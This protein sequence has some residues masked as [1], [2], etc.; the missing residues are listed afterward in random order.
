MRTSADTRRN[1]SPY[2]RRGC[3]RFAAF[4][5]SRVPVCIQGK[6]NKYSVPLCLRNVVISPVLHTHTGKLTLIP[7]HSSIFLASDG[8]SS[9]VTRITSSSSSLS[10]A[11]LSG[12][13]TPHRRQMLY[14]C[15][16]RILI[17]NR[18]MVPGTY[19]R[20]PDAALRLAGEA[21]KSFAP[22]RKHT[23]PIEFTATFM[24]QQL[25]SFTIAALRKRETHWFHCSRQNEPEDAARLTF[26]SIAYGPSGYK[27]GK[28]PHNC[29]TC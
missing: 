26:D 8:S 28:S 11:I 27:G 9:S 12:L 21:R 19:R 1:R 18:S 25:F 17:E 2:P 6:Q 20:A 3:K 15:W 13:S 22:F 23:A 4:D 29:Q 7:T 24:H 10:M 14:T 16:R 5:R